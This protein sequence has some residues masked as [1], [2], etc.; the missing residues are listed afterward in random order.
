MR[1][2]DRILALDK[3]VGPI[4]SGYKRLGNKIVLRSSNKLHKKL[5]NAIMELYPWC[6]SVFQHFTTEGE[7]RKPNLLHMAGS[8]L[9]EVNHKE[10]KVIYFFDITKVTFSGGNRS[11]RENLV[12]QV[13]EG[14]NLLDMFSA[15]GNLS[16]QPLVKKNINGLLVEKNKDTFFYLKKTLKINNLDPNTAINMDCREIKTRNWANRIFLGYHNVDLSHI[17]AAV[18][19]AQDKAIFHLHPLGKPKNYHEWSDKYLKWFKQCDVVPQV[20]S[21]AKIKNYS[22]GLD[23]IE[24]VITIK[25]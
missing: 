17:K 20:S 15:V 7:S 18:L 23:H 6:E 21:I 9:T 8:N 10:N 13:N 14:E 12:K 5:G 24:V 2:R 16:L 11:L 1:F 4:P 22:P 3:D 19:A 25:K